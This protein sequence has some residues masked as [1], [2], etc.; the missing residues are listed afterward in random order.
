MYAALGSLG[1]VAHYLVLLLL[2]ENALATPLRASFAGA[3]CGAAI[4]YFLHAWITFKGHVPSVTA[5]GSFAIGSALSLLINM[6]VMAALLYAALHYLLAQI[7]A[8]ICA[9]VFNFFYSKRL[10]FT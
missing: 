7:T 10:V 6:A 9:L 3:V 8:T 1:T 2:V 5:F 4:N